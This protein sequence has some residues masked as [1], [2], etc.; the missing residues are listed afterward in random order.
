MKHFFSKS[1]V[2]LLVLLASGAYAQSNIEV[3]ADLKNND[4][5]QKLVTIFTDE[6]KKS[7][8][9]INITIQPSASYNGKGFYLSPA[10]TIGAVKPPSGLQKAG[11]EAYSIDANEQT[12]KIFGNCNMAVGHGIFSYLEL[13]GY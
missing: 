3:F 9:E 7:S 2:A 13:I 5:L 6:L 8:P 4:S 11:V 12:V 1:S 10:T